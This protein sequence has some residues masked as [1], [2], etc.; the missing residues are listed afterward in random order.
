MKS[1][2]LTIGMIGATTSASVTLGFGQYMVGSDGRCY[3]VT[4]KDGKIQTFQNVKP[5]YCE[6]KK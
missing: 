1:L 5:C 2:F 4:M 3:F 6:V